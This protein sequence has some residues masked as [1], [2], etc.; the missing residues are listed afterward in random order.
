LVSAKAGLIS[1]I[2]GKV[3]LDEH[4]V[5]IVKTHFHVIQATASKGQL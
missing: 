4:A 2:E 1:C 5:E 3:Y